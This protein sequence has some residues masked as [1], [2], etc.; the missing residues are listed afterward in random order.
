MARPTKRSNPV[1]INTVGKHGISIRD[2][3]DEELRAL[4]IKLQGRIEKR[5]E[6]PVVKLSERCIK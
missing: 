6:R 2:L 5:Q 4:N 3:S 1:Y